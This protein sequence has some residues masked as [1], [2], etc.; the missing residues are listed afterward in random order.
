MSPRTFACA[1][2][3]ALGLVVAAPA[4]AD[5]ATRNCGSVAFATASDN[6]AFQIRATGVS[7]RTARAIARASRPAAFGPAEGRTSATYRIRRFRCRGVA[8]TASELPALRYTCRRA[9]ARVR[10]VRS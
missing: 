4:S 2:A 10:F 9:A 1:A 3:V 6:G 5:G 7:C 8:D